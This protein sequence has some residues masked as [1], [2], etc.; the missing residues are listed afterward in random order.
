MCVWCV[1][2]K[3]CFVSFVRDF[4]SVVPVVRCMFVMCLFMFDVWFKRVSEGGHVCA[5]VFC[6]VVYVSGSVIC[7][8]CIRLVLKIFPWI[9]CS[10][11]VLLMLRTFD[12]PR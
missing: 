11:V 2:V 7:L 8:F 1:L 5:F 12:I 10:M 9:C 4:C 6:V 3:C